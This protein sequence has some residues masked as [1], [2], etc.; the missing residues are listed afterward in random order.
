MS[1]QDCNGTTIPGRGLRADAGAVNRLPRELMQDTIG[2]CD[3]DEL[4]LDFGQPWP[5]PGPRPRPRL[6]KTVDPGA[7]SR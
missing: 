5:S 4:E 1:W 7:T 2:S 3:L 6:R